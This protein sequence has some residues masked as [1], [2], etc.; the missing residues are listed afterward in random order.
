MR[1]VEVISEKKMVKW[2]RCGGE[3]RRRPQNQLTKRESEKCRILYY[4]VYSAYCFVGMT[5]SVV[6]K[7]DTILVIYKYIYFSSGI[8]NWNCKYTDL[9][10]LHS[11]LVTIFDG[12]QICHADQGNCFP[13]KVRFS[14][15][16]IS[17]TKACVHMA[18]WWNLSQRDH[19]VLHNLVQSTFMLECTLSLKQK[20]GFNF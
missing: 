19:K 20:R 6:Q 18:L 2:C 10:I 5:N 9:N 4:S 11:R 15:C 17:F 16:R 8:R 14:S 12:T 1:R 3:I 7:Y 13:P